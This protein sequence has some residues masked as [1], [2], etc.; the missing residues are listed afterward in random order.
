MRLAAALALVIGVAGLIVWMVSHAVAANRDEA[1]W[2]PEERYGRAGRRVV[3][4][5][6]GFGMAGLSAEF[7][8]IDI[9]GPGVILLA[10]A[11]AAAAAWW[12]GSRL[13]DP[14]DE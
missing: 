6:V 8:S 4:G 2:D 1:G 10:I 11:G 3:G 7:A 13:A 9:P 14:S 12:S 5:L